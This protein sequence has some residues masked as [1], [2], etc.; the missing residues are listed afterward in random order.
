M[1][2]PDF[3]A[4]YERH[5]G[6][7]HRF[8]LYLSGNEA[9]AEDLT[10][11]TFVRAWIARGRIREGSVKAYLLAIARNL[12][13]DNCRR[14]TETPLPDDPNAALDPP[15]PGTPPDEAAHARR[16]LDVVLRALRQIPELDRAVLL[17]A[18]IEGMPHQ[19][20]GAALG[21]STAAV[22]VRVHRAR[23]TLNAVRGV[24]GTTP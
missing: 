3:A 2:E 8:A 6:D 7:V 1:D 15:D 10:A 18:T 5:S 19:A 14:V 12:Y 24:G 16:E 20:I 21:L 17:M 11:E 22:K 23:V 13:R 9:T 4:L